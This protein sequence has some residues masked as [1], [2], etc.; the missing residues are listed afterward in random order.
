MPNWCYNRAVITAKTEE[1]IT[2]F[3]DFASQTHESRW[4]N[5]SNGKIEI[6]QYNGVFWNFVT[7]PDVETYFEGNTAYFWNLENWDTKWDIELDRDYLEQIDKCA[8]GYF[9]NWSFDTAWSPALAVYLA[10]SKRFP[11]LEFDFEIT[12][13]ANLY[14]AK[15]RY[16]GGEIVEELFISSPTHEEFEELDIPCEL[17]GWADTG[18]CRNELGE[19]E[20][21]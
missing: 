1:E 5:H 4:K 18:D 16:R 20:E 12:E 6:E 3:L 14:V 13:E 17:C 7:P 10:M 11:T 21:N 15:L 19:S 8:D 9:L 2:A